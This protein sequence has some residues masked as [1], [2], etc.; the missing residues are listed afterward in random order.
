MFYEPAKRNHGHAHDPLLAIVAPRPIGWISSVST[1]GDVNLAP[2]SYFNI[3]SV[4]P[5]IVGFSSNG[6]KD[7]LTN[8]EQTRQFVCNL[9]VQ[10]LLEQLNLTSARLP[11]GRDEMAYARLE[12]APSRLV[13]PPRVAAAPCALECAWVE[14]VHLKDSRGQASENFLVLG[15]VMGVHISDEFVVDGKVDVTKMRSLARCGYM[16][17]AWVE[18]VVHVPRPPDPSEPEEIAL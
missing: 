13:K 12:P 2:Y 3:F 6:R 7:T 15:E 9:A 16:D 4:R 11:R 5:A 10:P 8:V 18:S 14:T 17:Y 1:K